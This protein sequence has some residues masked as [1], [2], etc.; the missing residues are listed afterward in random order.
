MQIANGRTKGDILGNF[1]HF[2]KNVGQSTVDLALVSDDLFPKL[3]DFKVLPQNFYSDHCKIILS[4]TNF[5]PG[6]ASTENYE[7]QPLQKTYKWNDE[8]PLKYLNA[9]NSLDIDNL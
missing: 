7:W 3:E 2:N 6:E 9:L 1:T 4:L 5:R 8:S